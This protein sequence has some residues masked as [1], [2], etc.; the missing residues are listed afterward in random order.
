MLIKLENGIKLPKKIPKT[1]RATTMAICF[2]LLSAANLLL[3]SYKKLV[4]VVKI[5]RMITPA[6]TGS[7]KGM[8]FS[9]AER[10][11]T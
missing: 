9:I 1:E 5:A 8:F 3:I 11:G 4:M 2:L 6:K 10:I 7:K